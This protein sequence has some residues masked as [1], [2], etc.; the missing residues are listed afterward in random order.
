MQEHKRGVKARWLR[1]SIV[2][3]VWLVFV[4]TFARQSSGDA[5]IWTRLFGVPAM[6][7][8]FADLSQ[9]T[10][11]VESARH[12]LDPYLTNPYDMAKRPYI[13][14]R[15]WL[16][17]FAAL[18]ITPHRIVATGIALAACFL[19]AVSWLI[20][21]QEDGLAA[22]FIGLAT[23]SSAT[24]FAIERG[25]TDLFVFCLV[26][27]ASELVNRGGLW[28]LLAASLLKVY[29]FFALLAEAIMGWKTRLLVVALVLGAAGIVIQHHAVDLQDTSVPHGYGFKEIDL[30]MS[31][32][33]HYLRSSFTAH[34]QA[35]RVV[36]DSLL[37]LLC[38][39]GLATGAIWGRRNFALNPS[40]TPE[41]SKTQGLA[42]SHAFVLCA[43]IFAGTFLLST[44]YDYRL[45]FLIPMAPFLAGQARAR[46]GAQ[47]LLRNLAS[48]GLI[49]IL[50]GVHR[51][52]AGR[53][54]WP[55]LA[56]SIK[57][58]SHIDLWALLWTTCFFLGF[59]AVAEY[60]AKSKDPSSNRQKP[61]RVGLIKGSA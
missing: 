2:A 47:R 32:A 60:H 57:V 61:L 45:I 5:T 42:G 31:R 44:N 24:A 36:W 10:A 58:A 35:F 30:V 17:A 27:L 13:Y 37:G 46:T 6:A 48:A 14:P 3:I 25:N 55:G 34:T 21:Q 33:P 11:A 23:C 26:V 9:I 53:I 18:R 20:L 22:L 12:G 40:R 56:M 8:P 29:P 28:F 54:P 50:I 7:G 38:C 49:M 52:V 19:L 1:F 16:Y 59:I 41:D 39:S 15:V 4:I 43:S 51:G